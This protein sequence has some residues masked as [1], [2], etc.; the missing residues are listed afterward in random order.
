MF[1]LLPSRTPKKQHRH[2]VR[3]QKSVGGNRE[4][5]LF[6]CRNADTKE[7]TTISRLRM[8]TAS[9]LTPQDQ[10]RD[11]LRAWGGRVTLSHHNKNL[12]NYQNVVHRQFM[13]Q[14]FTLARSHSQ[15]R[16]QQFTSEGLCNQNENGIQQI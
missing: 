5:T 13:H 9:C 1:F 3:K 11:P 16:H 12:I 4:H 10:E 14:K 8:L 6:A 2:F 15:F 7:L